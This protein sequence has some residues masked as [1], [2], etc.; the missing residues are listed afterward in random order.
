MFC[1]IH[2]QFGMLRRKLV[3]V[4]QV[5]VALAA[6]T[7]SIHALELTAMGSM[8]MAG[9]SYI[10][11]SSAVVGEVTV[12]D[13]NDSLRDGSA[14]GSFTD[15]PV[16]PFPTPILPSPTLTPT[17]SSITTETP[18]PMPTP[19]PTLTPTVTPTPTPTPTPTLTPTPPSTTKM[20]ASSKTPEVSISSPSVGSTKSDSSK[21]DPPS[22]YLPTFPPL[23]GVSD[24]HNNE[25]RQNDEI[26]PI[27][28]DTRSGANENR[29][30]SVE[31]SI[32]ALGVLG[33]VMAA[34]LVVRTRQEVVGYFDR[35]AQRIQLD[36]FFATG[37]EI[38][39]KSDHPG[40][41]SYSGQRITM[42]PTN[43][44]A[45]TT[46]DTAILEANSIY[47]KSSIW[48]ISSDFD[49]NESATRQ[50]SFLGSRQ[51][52]ADSLQRTSLS[53]HDSS[54]DSSNRSNSSGMRWISESDDRYTM[55]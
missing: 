22:T 55:L 29:M 45:M 52:S 16:L 34:V 43:E 13:L 15:A 27:D 7:T 14:N 32:I 35:D 2:S 49:G 23:D 26:S 42:T 37:N 21:N 48:E 41:A 38:V 33:C 5:V 25:N 18:T 4:L 11:E 30:G 39:P 17:P 46:R 8:T 10:S 9:E 44:T 19:S 31:I 20:P 12:G 50:D 53:I 47:N 51:I 24:D 40:A 6:I 3:V 1:A 36:Y 54:S 28:K